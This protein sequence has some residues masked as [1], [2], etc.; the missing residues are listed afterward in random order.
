M[1][2]LTTHS[3]GRMVMVTRKSPQ[4]KK[5]LSYTKDRRN[6]YGEN[7]KSSRK[8]IRRNKRLPNRADRRHG[9]QMMATATGAVEAEVSDQAEIK[10]RSTRSVWDKRG[11]RK[12]PDIPLGEIVIRKLERRTAHE[13]RS[14]NIAGTH[15]CTH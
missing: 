9:R 4:E 14:A 10:L 13:I 3:T 1:R 15:P 7:D 8:A 2:N 12:Q 11:W 5:I 6:D